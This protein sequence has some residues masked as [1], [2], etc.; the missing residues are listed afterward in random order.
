MASLMSTL[1]PASTSTAGPS[2]QVD[3]QAA[4]RTI[5]AALMH[6]VLPALLKI[7]TAAA[8]KALQARQARFPGSACFAVKSVGDVDTLRQCVPEHSVCHQAWQ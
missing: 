1:L 8:R 6:M 3:R 2:L 7:S 5:G 4:V